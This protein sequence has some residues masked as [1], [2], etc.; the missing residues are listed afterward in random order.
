MKATNPF[1]IFRNWYREAVDAG[2]PDPSIMILATADAGGNPSARIVLLK[3][4]DEKGFVFYTNYH[5]RKGMDLK[6]NPRAAL[7]LHWRDTGRQVRIEGLA[8]KV[9]SLASDRYFKSRPRGSQLGAWA[10]EQSHMIPSKES[11]DESMKKW[12]G[13]FRN[14]SVPRPPHWGGYRVVPD[15]MEFWSDREN[16]M[17]ERILFEKTAGDWTMKRLAP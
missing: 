8:E 17:H 11:L 6:R 7:V 3:S 13:A 10:S 2:I 5:S 4:F 14:R 9:S 1:D 12:E 16:R 15:R